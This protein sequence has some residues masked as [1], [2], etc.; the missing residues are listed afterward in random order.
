MAGRLVCR[1]G[2]RRLALEV[3]SVQGIAPARFVRRVPLAPPWVFGV[4]E[5]RGS[6]V[7]VV[8]P[9][10]SGAAGRDSDEP[11]ILV[12]LAPPLSHFAL[13]VDAAIEVI[14]DDPEDPPAP[15]DLGSWLAP[16]GIPPGSAG[17]K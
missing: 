9:P 4:A 2:G 7:T 12:R 16:L 14:D 5:W 17:R 1:I 8:A 15:L 13:H 11:G 3:A 10:D 6:V